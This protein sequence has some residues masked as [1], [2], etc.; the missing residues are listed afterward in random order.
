MD[1]LLNIN[2]G[3]NFLALD[4]FSNDSYD[5][6]SSIIARTPL[7]LSSLDQ[8][9]LILNFLKHFQSLTKEKILDEK[10]TEDLIVFSENIE[11]VVLSGVKIPEVVDFL[12]V[13]LKNEGPEVLVGSKRLIINWGFKRIDFIYGTDSAVTYPLSYENI[14]RNPAVLRLLNYLRIN[15]GIYEDFEK[16]LPLFLNQDFY[17]A[18][19]FYGL[20]IEDIVKL[21][22]RENPGWDNDLNEIILTGEFVSARRDSHELIEIVG[23]AAGLIGIFEFYLDRF[24]FFNSTDISVFKETAEIF[25]YLFVPNS[26]RKFSHT[27]IADQAK[28]RQ[29]VVL[30]DS[31][32]RL[33]ETSSVDSLEVIVEKHAFKK[34]V[35]IKGNYTFID[36]RDFDYADLLKEAI[37]N[38]AKLTRLLEDWQR[39]YKGVVKDDKEIEISNITFPKFF[40]TSKGL[41]RKAIGGELNIQAGVDS[42]VDANSAIGIY[43]KKKETFALDMI[44]ALGIFDDFYKYVE[45]IEGQHVNA[46]DLLAVKKSM[47][48]VNKGQ[49]T[50]PVAGT[51]RLSNLEYGFIDIDYEMNDVVEPSL[52]KGR[53]SKVIPGKYVEIESSAFRTRPFDVSGLSTHGEFVVDFEG[54][55]LAGKIIFVGSTDF[56]L[57]N[58]RKLIQLG[59]KGIVFDSLIYEKWHILKDFVN[60]SHVN[61]GIAIFQGFNLFR[62]DQALMKILKSL[63]GSF[64]SLDP[65]NN[66]IN[67]FIK[68]EEKFKLERFEKLYAEKFKVKDIVTL[69]DYR[70]WGRKAEIVDIIKDSA[71]VRIDDQVQNISLYN[72]E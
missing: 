64:V 59:V 26:L 56:D 17:L 3:N 39:G 68:V 21:V 55:D 49:L 16:A 53:V 42:L 41:Y 34:D 14:T 25:N 12:D 38:N 33:V 31:R 13:N 8:N 10:A 22:K 35:E 43:R 54:K 47:L 69:R 27:F 44:S 19:I 61:L 40:H 62:E 46:G 6:I 51:V 5:H 29:E 11:K 23:S 72:M 63:E 15:Q 52:V 71:L 58:V 9:K 67:F 36:T 45:V 37:K 57:V 60:G 7:S 65:E 66:I 1:R 50:S 24:N 32:I 28:S 30:D 70:N 4:L 20:I 2:Y 48:G 18:H